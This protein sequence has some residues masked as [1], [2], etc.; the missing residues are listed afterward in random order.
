MRFGQSTSRLSL[1]ALV[2]VFMSSPSHAVPSFARQTGM[3]CSACH[4][5]AFGPN[6]TPYGRD[7]KLNG[8][9]AASGTGT[10]LPPLS[11]MI[12]GS[13][14]HTD[15]GQ[16]GG[17]ATG[18]NANNNVALDQAAIFFAGRIASKFGAFVELTYDGVGDKLFLDNTDLRF[19]DNT[20]LGGK[21]LVYGISLNNSPTVQDLWNTTPVWSFPFVSS[22]LAPTPAA[23][24][25]IDSLGGQVGGATAYMMWNNTLYVEAGGYTTFAHDMQRALGTFDAGQ[26]RIAGGAPYWRVAL[27]HNWNGHYGA[28]G[29]FGLQA[30]VNP[31]RIGTSGTDKYTDVGFDA[32][33]QYLANLAHIVE[34]NGAFIHENRRL[35]ASVPLGFAEKLNSRLNTFRVHGTYTYQQ[36]YGMT[37]GYFQTWGTADA[38]LFGSTDP[39]GGSLA[40]KPNNQAVTA[41]LDYIPF[42]KSSSFLAPW[43]NLRFGLQYVHYFQFNGGSSNYAGSD[44]NAVNNDTLYLNGWLAF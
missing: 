1:L 44:R 9:T 14:T 25:L 37:L 8:Y 32:T 35:E 7:F 21:S 3:P 43:L 16:P 17:A 12:Q 42:G 13:F 19:A 29:Y 24:T 20:K 28:V 36:T 5:Q 40:G 4:T 38:L 15:K 30:D 10:K 31:Q 33:Y 34:L 11:A 2:L 22:A 39:I 23:G 27:Q 41:E 6:L 18:Y 26:N